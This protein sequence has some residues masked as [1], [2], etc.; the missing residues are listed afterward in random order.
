[1]SRGRGKRRHRCLD[2]VEAGQGKKHITNRWIE[3]DGQIERS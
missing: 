3:T 1:M 2:G